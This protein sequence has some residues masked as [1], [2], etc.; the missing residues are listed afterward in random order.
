MLNITNT[1]LS[2]SGNNALSENEAMREIA[3]S[4]DLLIPGL[5][6]WLPGILMRIGG[7]VPDDQPYK[8]PGKIHSRIGIALVLPGYK[9]FTSYQG[10]Y[11]SFG[12]DLRKGFH[13]LSD[14][15]SRF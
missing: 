2:F 3:Y 5:Y 13:Y 10:T 11:D 15:T 1:K 7:D 14:L 4:M 8:Y 6:L 12:E 9:I